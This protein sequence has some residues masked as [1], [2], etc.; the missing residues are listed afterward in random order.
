M[1]RLLNARVTAKE[2][3]EPVSLIAAVLLLIAGTALALLMLPELHPRTTF[4]L[5]AAIGV[6]WLV[7]GQVA[8]GLRRR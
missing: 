8:W 2:L 6:G 1:R 3:D 7:L 4:F 5:G